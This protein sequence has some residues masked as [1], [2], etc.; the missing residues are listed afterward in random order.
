MKADKVII[1][2]MAGTSLMTLFS[3]IASEYKKE[4]FSEPELLAK[5]IDDGLPNGQKELAL[6]A[7]WAAHYGIG[8][9]FSV[10]Y[11]I[12]L[13]IL[14]AKPSALNGLLFGAA[15]GVI[16]I[17]SWKLFFK[18]HPSPPNIDFKNYYRQLFLAH[19]VFGLTA[20]LT[21]KKLKR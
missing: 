18:S 16:G 19:C 9:S 10:V 7:G 14:K 21:S 8:L 1:S 11:H 5:L 17:A 2:G 4:N 12:M 15:G 3:Y 20:A 13:K 6:P